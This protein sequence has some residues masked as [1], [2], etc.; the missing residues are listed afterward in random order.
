MNFDNCNSIVLYTYSGDYIDYSLTNC[1]EMPVE[2]S[3]DLIGFGIGLGPIATNHIECIPCGGYNFRYELTAYHKANRN[4][5]QIHIYT[6]VGELK[7]SKLNIAV[8]PN[9]ISSQG[10]FFVEKNDTR[11]SLLEIIDISGKII[12]SK[13]L[14]E[15]ISVIDANEFADG[16][17]FY[18]VTS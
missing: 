2:P 11:E 8:Y 12:L 5:G 13:Q 14:S 17:Y 10:N 7:G 1:F 16:F 9:P 15:R 6:S 3:M 18:R 4:C